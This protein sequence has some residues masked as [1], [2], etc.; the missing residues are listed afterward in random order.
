MHNFCL[1]GLVSSVTLRKK[2]SFKDEV[3]VQFTD[4]LDQQS[5]AGNNTF[6]DKSSPEK[7]EVDITNLAK[8]GNPSYI[9]QR[10]KCR[11]PKY[12]EIV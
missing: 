5:A 6:V 3:R 10:I 12:L 4:I 1:D 9:R 8:R 11:R 2:V 7:A